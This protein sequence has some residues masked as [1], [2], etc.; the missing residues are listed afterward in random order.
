MKTPCRLLLLTVVLLTVTTISCATAPS[1]PDGPAGLLTHLLRDTNADINRVCSRIERVN[2]EVARLAAQGSVFTLPDFC[3]TTVLP[4]Y[5]SQS[6]CT[7]I[8]DDFGD[9]LDLALE[10]VCVYESWNCDDD[11][12][13]RCRIAG[14]T[15]P[16]PEP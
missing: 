12:R 16:D 9:S 5:C 15:P 1:S 6:V 2:N 11:F 13:C 10:G 7:C 3:E 14:C 8:S 4:F